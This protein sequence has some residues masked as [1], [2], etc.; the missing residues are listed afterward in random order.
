MITAILLD[1]EP[2]VLELNRL[3]VEDSNEI[4][5]LATFTK[6]SEAMRAL[7]QLK[8]NVCF[9]DIEMSGMNG[10]ELA[11]KI[12]QMNIHTE[13]VFVTAYEKYSIEAFGAEAFDYILKPIDADSVNRVIRKWNRRYSLATPSPVLQ[14]QGLGGLT[15]YDS[16]ATLTNVK[17]R[18]LKTEEVLAYFLIHG[19]RGVT[20]DELL[21]ELWGNDVTNSG[22]VHTTVYRL[23]KTLERFGADKEIVYAEGRYR[24]NTHRFS[25]DFLD[26]EEELRQAASATIDAE[27]KFRT[28][29]RYHGALFEGRDYT[30]VLTHRQYL[31]NQFV[32]FGIQLARSFD[33]SEQLDRA[34]QCCQKLLLHAPSEE[35]A[36]ELLLNIYYKRQERSAF[37]RQFV[38]YRNMLD[39]ELGIAMKQKWHNLY[40]AF[41][42]NGDF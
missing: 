22:V 41:I 13:I 6:V 5:V 11:K 18:S 32:Q 1:D 4:Q 27:Q 42:I 29:M 33:E 20:R 37:I 26:F 34:E 19:R 10:L 31:H 14:I 2:H 15:F 28:L 16:E 40:D 38:A 21:E 23:K 17:W 39:H 8:P 3:V 12:L 24:L 35:E 36:H 9:I 30:W 25:I 7:P